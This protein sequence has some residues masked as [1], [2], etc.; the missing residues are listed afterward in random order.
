MP[1]SDVV[2]LNAGVGVEAMRALSTTWIRSG[3]DSPLTT[4]GNVSA[5]W[6]ERKQK[7]R[8]RIR[9]QSG[10]RIGAALSTSQRLNRHSRVGV[11]EQLAN[12]LVT[13]AVRVLD[14]F[15][16]WDDDRNGTVSR[17]EFRMVLPVLGLQVNKADAD[18]LFDSIDKDGSGSIDMEEMLDIVATFY[19]MEGKPRS[20][21]KHWKIMIKLPFLQVVEDLTLLQE[22]KLATNNR[23]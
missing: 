15:R 13:N 19:D 18:A 2:I 20:T 22:E 3:I 11:I 12:L 8:H 7:Q 17:K 10:G 4:S 5:E 1:H 9:R 21:G 23:A 14:L 6:P 16:D